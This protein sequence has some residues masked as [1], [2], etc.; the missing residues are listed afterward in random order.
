MEKNILSCSY[1]AA[2]VAELSKT[3]YFDQVLVVVKDLDAK[4][5][6][7]KSTGN[8]GVTVSWSKAKDADGYRI[9]IYKNGVPVGTSTS[10][11]NTGTGARTNYEIIELS[12]S[13]LRT[14]GTG[15]YQIKVSRNG[16]FV[17]TESVKL[18]VAWG[19][20]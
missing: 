4:V 11:A 15:T 18:G 7:I 2:E 19:Q 5:K 8:S 20:R 9:Y 10:L 12:P 17:G 16:S 1:T 13:T 3:K 14:Y 6:S